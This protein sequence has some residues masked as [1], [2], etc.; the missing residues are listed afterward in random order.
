MPSNKQNNIPNSNNLYA[1]FQAQIEASAQLVNVIVK[2]GVDKNLVKT[3]KSAAAAMD[4]A[5]D[6]IYK[7]LEKMNSM[8]VGKAKTAS[9]T[10]LSTAQAFDTLTVVVTNINK[11]SGSQLR[12]AQRSVKHLVNLMIGKSGKQPSGIISMIEEIGDNNRAKAVATGIKLLKYIPDTIR[13]LNKMAVV[14]GASLPMVVLSIITVKSFGIVINGIMGIYSTASDNEK[15]IIGAS[16]AL[17]Q[18]ASSLLLFTGDLALIGIAFPLVALSAISIF[19]ISLVVKNILSIY[20]TVANNEANVNIASNVFKQMTLSLIAIIGGISVVGIALPMVGLAV[21]ATFALSMVVNGL[22]RIYSAVANKENDIN[23]ASKVFNQMSLSLLAIVGSVSLIGIAFPLV[24]LSIIT[25]FA[26][27]M[28]IK[29]LLGIYS[30]IA[31]KEPDITTAS[32]MFKQMASDMLILTG[33]ISLIGIAFPLVTLGVITTFALALAI[34]GL[35]HVYSGIA[36]R[37]SD[38]TTTSKMFKQM[39]SD[40]LILTGSISLIGIAFP[41]VTLGAITAFALALA[42][43][44]L[45]R[46]YSAVADKEKDITTASKVFKQM[47]SSLLIIVGS[48]SLIGIAFPLVTLGV[49]TTFALT[50]VI[51]GLLR[52]Y[53]GIAAKESDINIASKALKQMA[54]SLLIIVGSVSLVSVAFPLVTISMITV[55]TL[56]LVIKGILRIYSVVANKENDINTASKTLKQMA[57]SLLIIVGSVSIIG[58]AT[59][60]VAISLIT[61]FTL[62]LVIKGL[63]HIYSV[64]ANHAKDIN[65]S[66]RTFNQMSMSLLVF[67]GSLVIVGLT[68]VIAAPLIAVAMVA[69]L[70]IIGLMVLMSILSKSVKEGGKVLRDMALAMLILSTTALLMAVTGQFIV[71]NWESMLIVSAYLLV[72]VGSCLLLALAKKIINEGAKELLYLA[73]VVTIL[74]GT[75]MLMAVVGQ[76]ITANWENM[77]IMSAYLLVLVGSCL[78]LAL[79]KKW[80]ESGAKELLFIALA[81]TILAGVALLMVYVGSLLTVNWEPVLAVTLLLTVLVGATYLIARASKTIQKGWVAMLI[82][83]LFAAAM[84]AVVYVLVEISNTADPLELLKVVGIMALIMVAVGGIAVVAGVLQSQIMQGA[85]A[86]A[87]ISGISFVMSIVMKN[88]ATA[89][90]IAPPLEILEVTGIMALIMVAVGAMTIASGMLLAGPQAIAFGLGMAAMSTLIVVALLLTQVVKNTA[91]AAIAVKAAGLKDPDEVAAIISLPIKAFTKEDKDG[92]SLFG[93]IADL[94]NPIKMASYVGKVTSL[95]KITVSI[96]RIADILQHIAS[97]NMPDPDKGYDEKGNPKGYKQ[98]KSDDFMAAAQNA[99][100]IL[101]MTS[102]MFGEEQVD[103]ELGD[104]AKFTVVPCDMA[105]LDKISWA[106]KIKIKRLSKIVGYVSDMADTLQHIASLKIPDPAKGFTEEGRP[107]G[108]LSMT[109]SDFMSAA[110]NAG[111]ILVFFTSLF[112][113]EATDVIF[114]GSKITVEPLNMQALENVSRSTR[115]KVKRLGEIVSV[116]GGMA[117]NLQNISSLLIPDPAKGFTE[118]GKPKG[119]TVM[120]SDDFR[121]AAVNAGS[122]LAFFANIFAEEPSTME[123]AGQQVTVT[124]ISLA[125]LDNLSRGTKKKIARLGE[126][127]AVVG[128]MA[129]TLKNMSSLTVPDAMGPDDFNENGTPKRWRQMT[130]DDI[131]NAAL[132]AGSM[133]EFFCALFGDESKTLSLG[134]L[135]AVVI[136]PISED[137]LD[138]ISRSTKKKM[139]RLGEIIA[140]VGGLGETLKNLSSLIVPDCVTAED[141]NENGTPKKWRKMTQADFNNAMKMAEKMLLSVVNILGDESMQDKLS[142]ISRR[143]MQKLGIAMDAVKG[144]GNIMD[145]VKSLAGGRMASK[146][147]R[148][149]DPN[150]PTYGQDIAVEYINLAEFIR[151]NEGKITDTVYDL[152]MCPIKAIAWIADSKTAMDYVKKADDQ[153]YKI[154]RVLNTIKQPITDIID[155]YN[156]KLSGV[157]VDLIRPTFEGVIFGVVSPLADLDPDRMELVKK[158]SLVVFERVAA[159]LTNVSKVTD[160]SAKNFQNNVKETVGLLKT[161]DSVNLDKL[162]TASDLMKHIEGLSKSINGNFKELAHAINEDLL[163]ALEKLTGALDEVNKKEF[164]VASAGD[165]ISSPTGSAGVVEKKEQQQPVRNQL[166][167]SDLDNVI[168]AINDL[169]SKVNRVI[170]DGKVQVKMT[171]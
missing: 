57:S 37:E 88:L 107:K 162:K 63:L 80:I 112:A 12:M 159:S 108:Y 97:L 56:S 81:V 87:I 16:I 119:F 10:L 124:P 104:G 78:L 53:S 55:F 13:D 27:S 157:D 168:R 95:A 123:F 158:G 141:F 51:K 102:A 83:V 144:L 17:K 150:S 44:G 59:P 160:N 109:S 131:S 100:V 93:Y 132:T 65:T 142:D 76:F 34:N 5:L 89:A 96:G 21:V 26:L 58:L 62:S 151:K 69:T 129:E 127:V 120:T 125:A 6:T 39:A 20:L 117:S 41:L 9:Q 11:I 92:K 61:I 49:I 7:S 50:L 24:A 149:R 105:A 140:V 31:A 35:L 22:L 42:I 90:S 167:K 128:G 91:K 8:D 169:T 143:N 153:G 2:S 73:L 32:K 71:A 171:P 136:N 130:A 103:F 1:I 106:T 54:S 84:A 152:I 147:E 114:G 163:E 86:V 99:A 60:L 139:E 116:V 122:I 23:I 64:V 74:A 3:I 75:A 82:V 161:V 156:D 43:N 138:N 133:L 148:D 30:S 146:W 137:A 33:S 68:F 165:V 48:V 145:L 85:I 47:A 70:A 98:M 14:L 115:R 4:T 18:M 28:A 166:T 15:Q 94:P 19:A 170:S 66:S 110:Q 46:I 52:I 126:I 38:I 154:T 36:A 155:L 164:N 72:L 113:D 134:S 29:G 25:V 40:M 77:L 121:N 118:D 67:V 45:L 135:G 79:A 111:S 101:G